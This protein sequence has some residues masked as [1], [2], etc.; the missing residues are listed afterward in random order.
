MLAP[1]NYT[2]DAR[3]ARSRELRVQINEVS[4]ISLDGEEEDGFD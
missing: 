4:D 1:K 2:R 3:S